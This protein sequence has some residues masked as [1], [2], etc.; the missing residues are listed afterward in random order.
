MSSK[1][2]VHPGHFLRTERRM[3]CRHKLDMANTYRLRLLG[4]GQHQTNITTMKMLSKITNLE[5]CA[6]PNGPVVS[7]SIRLRHR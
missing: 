6:R 4:I 5:P 2:C 7:P 1:L 3:S